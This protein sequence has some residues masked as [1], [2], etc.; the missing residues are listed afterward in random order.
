MESDIFR[1]PLPYRLFNATFYLIGANILVFILTNF[2][3][4]VFGTLALIP[5]LTLQH[6][7]WWQV[8]TYMF[9]HGGYLHILFNMVTLFLFGIQ[10]ERHMG[11]LEFLLFYFICGIGVGL[12][13]L[14]INYNTGLQTV[15][16]VGASGAIFGMLLAFATF[17][18]D[19][20]IF[21]F[22]IL[23]LRAPVAVL[24]FAAL[25]LFFQFTGLVS[26][27]AHLSH[28]FGLLI[29]YFYIL[30]RYGINPFR[31]FFRR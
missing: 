17:F 12:L 3:A 29:A 10:L 18:P 4:G 7:Y 22:G 11:S 19:S 30:I 24:V 26:G 31:V 2:V 13:T 16:V 21:I 23:P 15:P 25:E 6:N 20:R 14:L 1:R 27:V 28:L 5:V 8:V 9:V